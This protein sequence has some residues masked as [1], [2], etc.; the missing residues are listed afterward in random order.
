MRIKNGLRQFGTLVGGLKGAFLKWE[1][2]KFEGVFV[3][4]HSGAL[5]RGLGKALN[6][7]AF[8]IVLNGVKTQP[9]FFFFKGWG[10]LGAFKKPGG[11]GGPRGALKT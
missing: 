11:G 1:K 4:G 7:K 8:C 5:G 2:K 9:D 3:L 6:R 10:Q